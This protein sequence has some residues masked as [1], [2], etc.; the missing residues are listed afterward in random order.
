MT[1]IIIVMGRN[2]TF[3]RSVSPVLTQRGRHGLHGLHPTPT[4]RSP[5]VAIKGGNKLPQNVMPFI[6]LMHDPE[7]IL[8]ILKALHNPDM[9]FTRL[10]RT[11]RPENRLRT[12]PQ[13]TTVHGKIQYERKFHP[14]STE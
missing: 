9:I 2:N 10:H 8:K 11:I 12:L 7:A 3:V 6:R 1:D 14:H 5:P 13:F 4:L